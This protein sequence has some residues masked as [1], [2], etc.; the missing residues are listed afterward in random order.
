MRVVA[1]ICV[2]AASIE[3]QSNVQVIADAS[4]VMAGR[5]IKASAVARDNAGSAMNVTFRWS[6][7]S[8]AIASVSADGTV[9]AK[10]LGIVRI[11]A[12][13]PNN[14]EA[15]FCRRHADR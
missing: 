8:D 15:L 7:S 6:S 2:I 3:A 9:T 11:R 4:R 1:L 12:T 14:S 10:V 13:A 5:T